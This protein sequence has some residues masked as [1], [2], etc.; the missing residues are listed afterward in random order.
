MSMAHT[1]GLCDPNIANRLA[2]AYIGTG[3]ALPPLPAY[4]KPVYEITHEL[5]H[6]MGSD[7]THACAWTVNG[8]PNQ[9]LDDCGIRQPNEGYC[10]S[11]NP[12]IPP[13]NA[14]TIM[15]Y[16]N[17][18]SFST[19]F[20]EQQGDIKYQMPLV[21]RVRLVQHLILKT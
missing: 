13:Y 12:P 3:T 17:D 6:L 10:D 4:S 16:C 8:I 2:I 9:A 1:G 11:V 5:G 7:H 20:G 14:G 19:G 21:Y 15:S 18:F